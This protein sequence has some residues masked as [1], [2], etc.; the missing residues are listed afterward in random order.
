MGE[1]QEH[2]GKFNYVDL[3]GLAGMAEDIPPEVELEDTEGRE[4][5]LESFDRLDALIKP[6]VPTGLWV[7]SVLLATGFC[8]GFTTNCSQGPPI[9]Y[10]LALLFVI[11]FQLH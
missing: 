3:C 2:I 6:L 10:Y 9:Y 8:A 4:K 5:H 1:R 7:W 11:A